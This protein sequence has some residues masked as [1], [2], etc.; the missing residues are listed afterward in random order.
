[1]ISVPTWRFEQRVFQARDAFAAKRPPDAAPPL[2]TGEAVRFWLEL[3]SAESPD[4]KRYYPNR[5]LPE[6]LVAGGWDHEH[7]ELCGGHIDPA[8][9]GYL[10]RGGNWACATCYQRYIRPQ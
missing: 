8:Q 10:D 5:D 1:M 6:G 2:P 4:N 9:V 7:C 3:T